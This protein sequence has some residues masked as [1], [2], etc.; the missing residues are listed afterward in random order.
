[1]TKT[2]QHAALTLRAGRHVRLRAEVD[3]TPAGLMAIGALT[4]AIL[5]SSAVIVAVSTRHLPKRGQG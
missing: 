5:L 4:S 2:H 3:V 1:M